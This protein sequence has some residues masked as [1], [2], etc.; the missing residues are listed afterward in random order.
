MARPR[1][2]H[3]TKEAANELRSIVKAA[4]KEIGCPAYRLVA[5]E[6]DDREALWL[7]RAMERARPMSASV[8]R[9]VYFLVYLACIRTGAYESAYRAGG[10]AREHNLT[11]TP[12]LEP[13]QLMV[14]RG[15][16]RRASAEIAEKLRIY[17]R[18]G[19]TR[20][21]KAR[22]LLQEYLM[23]FESMND[24]AIGKAALAALE[25]AGVVDDDGEAP[26]FT[27]KAALDEAELRELTDAAALFK[28]S[29]T[30]K[31]TLSD[32]E[33]DQVSERARLARPRR[34]RRKRFAL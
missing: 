11:G 21:E 13:A 33:R 26:A 27:R 2:R 3:L 5:N 25:E 28:D 23:A 17:L 15:S 32:V 22:K 24:T 20:Y 29:E 10:F 4:A 30:T 9:M 34:S 18:L 7:R 12:R 19:P 1:K 6:Y 31:R 14:F 8:A 16:S